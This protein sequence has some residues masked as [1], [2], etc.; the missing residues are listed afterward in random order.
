[1]SLLLDLS[2][3]QNTILIC[4]TH[5]T[6]LADRFPTHQELRDGKLVDHIKTI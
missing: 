1:G 6:E 3:E 2:K 4:V 5:S